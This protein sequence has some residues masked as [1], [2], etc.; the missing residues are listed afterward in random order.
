MAK[1]PE[2]PFDLSKY[3]DPSTWPPADPFL[4]PTRVRW[5]NDELKVSWDGSGEG[6]IVPPFSVNPWGP[7]VGAQTPMPRAGFYVSQAAPDQVVGLLQGDVFS[8]PIPV[9]SDTHLKEALVRSPRSPLHP[10]TLACLLASPLETSW[11]FVPMN[12]LQSFKE[13]ESRLRAILRTWREMYSQ[14]LGL[15]RKNTKQIKIGRK[16][17]TTL[18]KRCDNLPWHNVAAEILRMEGSRAG[19]E[20]AL[21][22]RETVSQYDED[23]R[24]TLDHHLLARSWHVLVHALSHRYGSRDPSAVPVPHL[25]ARG[26]AEDWF[27]DYAPEWRYEGQG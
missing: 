12:L 20:A 3:L 17:C 10:M 23:L 8:G 1:R 6:S 26:I 19:M 11:I 2:E 4:Q 25:T 14:S 24:N 18:L 16:I 21:N 7:N 13:Q 27:T 9:A 15:S 22:E 5:K